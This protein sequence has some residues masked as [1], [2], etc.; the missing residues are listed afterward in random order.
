MACGLGVPR[1][2]RQHARRRTPCSAVALLLAVSSLAAEPSLPPPETLAEQRVQYDADDAKTIFEL[3]PWRTT[4]RVS[5]RRT[6]GAAGIATLINLNPYANAW[7]VLT[8]SWE[9]TP[10]ARSYHL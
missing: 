8:L 5:L 10:E 4:S 9:G 6:D 1:Y 7:Y 3:Q 2:P